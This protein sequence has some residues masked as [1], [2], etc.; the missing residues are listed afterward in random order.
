MAMGQALVIVMRSAVVTL[1]DD[2]SDDEAVFQGNTG[3]QPVV[4]N[5][6]VADHDSEI[7]VRAKPTR[8]AIADTTVE[9]SSSHVDANDDVSAPMGAPQASAQ[10][11]Q[12]GARTDDDRCSAEAQFT[13]CRGNNRDEFF[14]DAEADKC[15]SKVLERPPACLV[16]QN[17]FKSVHDCKLACLDREVSEDRCR[18]LP[19]FQRCTA[20]DIVRQWW[21]LKNGTCHE[22]KLPNSNCVSP[23]LALFES[24]EHCHSTCVAGS[25]VARHPACSETPVEHP[26]TAVH[27]VYPVLAVPRLRSR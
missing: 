2:D 5:L 18:S 11:K 6:P 27:M 21:Y 24:R 20:Q 16:G 12:E 19:R 3:A 8:G 14:F 9:S 15:R 13:T 22:W 25:P 4:R 7:I 1:V 10:P 26:C 17:R 23:R